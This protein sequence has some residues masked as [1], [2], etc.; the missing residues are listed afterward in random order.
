MPFVFS[1]RRDPPMSARHEAPPKA[2][3]RLTLAEIEALSATLAAAVAAAMSD[4]AD[5][6][7]LARFCRRHAISLQL[8]YKLSQQ[9]IAPQTFQAGS[10]ILI[11]R[12]AA[13]RWRAERE[14]ATAAEA[15]AATAA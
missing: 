14:A 12:E 13:A 4:E 6:F 11:S 2:A 9:G 1:N 3:A 8:F 15:A 10:R 5:A 7:S